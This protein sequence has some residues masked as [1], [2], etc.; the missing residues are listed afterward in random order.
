MS[1]SALYVEYKDS[2]LC[3]GLDIYVLNTGSA[4]ADDSQVGHCIHNFGGYGNKKSHKYICVLAVFNNDR[5]RLL[6]VGAVFLNF[7][8]A[9]LELIPVILKI[10]VLYYT[11]EFAQVL[12]K[13]L[14][15]TRMRDHSVAKQDGFKFF[16]F[17]FPPV[18]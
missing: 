11:S 18:N 9:V 6:Y 1:I 17:F 12:V 14:Y 2:A 8:S 16:H 10:A 7:K 4:Y 13:S 5:V 3:C 15:K